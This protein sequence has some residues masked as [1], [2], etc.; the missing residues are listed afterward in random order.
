MSADKTSNHRQFHRIFYNAEAKLACGEQC[1][2]C[3]ILDLSLK[4]CLLH[5]EQGWL[6]DLDHQYTLTLKLSDEIAIVMELSIVH[7]VG[8]RVG[9]RCEHIDIDSMSNLR[10]LVELNLGDSELLERELAALSAINL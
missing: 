6:G 9:F 3:E 10:R 1:Y 7:A 4:G 8:N 2:P 5:F